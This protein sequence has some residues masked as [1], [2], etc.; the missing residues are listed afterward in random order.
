MSQGSKKERHKNL[1]FR[2]QDC[3]A[4]ARHFSSWCPVWNRSAVL[5][6]Y[7]PATFYQSPWRK[8]VTVSQM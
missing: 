4:K 6:E 8:K 7:Q 3:G 5:E 2:R 1:D